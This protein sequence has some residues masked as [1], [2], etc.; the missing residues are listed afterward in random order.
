MKVYLLTCTVE[1]M[2]EG[3]I[4][5]TSISLYTDKDAAINEVVS[6]AEAQKRLERNTMTEC[7]TFEGDA[8]IFVPGLVQEGV[9]IYLIR[10]R[11]VMPSYGSDCRMWRAVFEKEIK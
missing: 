6:L 4:P 3:A 7:F 10:T 1:R 2:E 8:Q 11:T 9:P 5:S